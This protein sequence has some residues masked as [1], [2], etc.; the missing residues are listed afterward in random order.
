MPGATGAFESGRK[1]ALSAEWLVAVA[2]YVLT[3]PRVDG[4]RRPLCSRR[5][6]EA[7]LRS[8]RGKRG[9]KSLAWALDRVRSPVH[10][11][12]ETRLRLGLVDQGLPEP[13]V[14]FEVQ[15]AAG[16]RHA[17]LGY[18]EARVLLEYQGD[19]HRTDAKQWRTDLT[20][21]QLF[22]DAG[23]RTIL[24]G[25]DDLGDGLPALASRVRRALAGKTFAA[26]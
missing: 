19:H 11:P 9:A 15:T 18:R 8:H 22:E 3:G 14:Q 26:S 12:Q 21:V 17:D 16:I 24:V 10:S 25:A 7:A 6:L 5:Q 23:Y 13:E 1:R 4:R 20:R 2:D